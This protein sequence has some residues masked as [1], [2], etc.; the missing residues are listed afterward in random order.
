MP[1][2]GFPKKVSIT[3]VHGCI[4]GYKVNYIL[5]FHKVKYDRPDGCSPEKDCLR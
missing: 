4:A 2:L 3:F 1:V 5:N